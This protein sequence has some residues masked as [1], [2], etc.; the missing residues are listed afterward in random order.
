MGLKSR[1]YFF[2]GVIHL[3][4]QE[5]GRGGLSPQVVDKGELDQG[6]EH[7]G[8]AH[9]HPDI[10]GLQKCALILDFPKFTRNGDNSS[11]QKLKMG[12][13]FCSWV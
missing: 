10:D 2:L 7:K 13:P 5:V 11:A 12:T 6:R 4:P 1:K 9:A 8:R 3:D